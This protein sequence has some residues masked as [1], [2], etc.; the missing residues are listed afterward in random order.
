MTTTQQATAP[1]VQDEQLERAAR[2]FDVRRII[3]GLFVLYGV[4]VGV[5]GLR[6]TDAEIA[7]AAGTNV[8]LWTG[9]GMLAVGVGFLVWQA[10]SPVRDV[11][12]QH[13]DDTVGTDGTDET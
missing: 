2:R 12:S 6:A 1:E 9:L 11:A 10:V 7:K 13:A 4:V 5:M 8:N 3:G